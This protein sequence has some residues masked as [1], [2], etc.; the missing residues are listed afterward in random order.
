MKKQYMDEAIWLA[1]GGVERGEGG[2][3]GAVVV[4][5]GK[6]VG[7]GWNRVIADCDPTAHAEVL[8]IRDATRRLG[9]VHLSGATLYASCE[10]CPMCLSA[11]Y[12]AHIDR[13]C[14]AATA[15]DA[16]ALGFNDSFILQQLRLPQ[17]QR[18]IRMK[19][20]MREE[21]LAVF[22]QWQESD[23]GQIY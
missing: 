10:P 16:A 11:A 8:A 20:L 6:I 21:A 18:R 19:P 3:F 7:R 5:A 17:R 15:A 12:W 1:A 9:E 22:R 13:V 2:P 4:K 23:Q 14:Y